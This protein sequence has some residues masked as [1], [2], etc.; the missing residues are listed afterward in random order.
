VSERVTTDIL[1][2]PFT[3]ESLELR[4]DAEGPVV[5][6][7]VRLPASSP[8]RRAV[9]HVHGFCDYF[10]NVEYARWWAARGYDFYALD[11]RKYGR[12]LR[13]HQTPGYVD[14]IAEYFE[15]LDLSWDAITRRDDH[16]SVLLSAHSTG[17][18]AMSLWSDQRQRGDAM[19]LNAPWI[20]MHGPFWVRLGSSVVR[21]LGSY[22]PRRE[23]PR[24]T[25][26]GVYGRS[27]HRDY[28]G[29]WDYDLALKPIE[30]W[31]VYAGW[32]RAIRKGH[33][34]LH[35]GLMVPGPVLVLTSAATL[36]AAELIP[37]AHTHDV[38]LDVTKIRRWATSI[39]PHVTSVAIEGA[40][41]DVTLSRAA[42]RTTLYEQ[43][44]R[45]LAAFVERPS[46]LAQK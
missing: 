39:G 22:Q 10:F 13:P 37:A 44:D 42:T 9:L 12:S 29:E 26:T 46:G 14:D 31:P 15:E 27:L 32:L 30:S 19:V 24:G 5:A 28:E 3:A 1:G 4:P 20:D 8:T 6:T 35:R 25:P 23:L 21:Q 17:G 18:L 41:H 38:V 33:A 36:R 43:L 40:R 45:W 7:L 2:T 16:D 34:R 11:L